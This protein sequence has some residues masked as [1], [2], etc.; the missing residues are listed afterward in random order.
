MTDLVFQ[1]LCPDAGDSLRRR[2]PLVALL[3]AHV[4]QHKK[5][6]GLFGTPRASLDLRVVST[7]I[8]QRLRG[9]LS[10]LLLYHDGRRLLYGRLSALQIVQ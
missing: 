3:A 6:G 8:A 2:A 1:R 7:C 10:S 4:D 9:A 5:V